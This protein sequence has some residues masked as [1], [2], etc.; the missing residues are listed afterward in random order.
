MSC[1]KLP[2]IQARRMI[3][4]SSSDR[5]LATLQIAK[6]KDFKLH[7]D[8]NVDSSRQIQIREVINRLGCRIHDIDQALVHPHLVLVPRVLVHERGAV[9]RHF[10]NLCRKRNGA[11]DLGSSALGRFH[12][13][14]SRLVDHLVIVGLDLDSD[15]QVR[16]CFGL[17]HGTGL[18]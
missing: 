8:L 10:V 18:I 1:E 4:T 3:N 17:F 6:N 13:L 11:S 12:D 9:H 15:A 7:F 5:R 2:R 16:R 14:A